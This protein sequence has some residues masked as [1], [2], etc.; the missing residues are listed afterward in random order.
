VT[1]A[2]G[3]GNGFPMAAVVTTKEV[4]QSL[5]SAL[6]LNTFGGNPM[7]CAVGDAVLDVIADERLQANC[8]QVGEHFLK[9]LV[10]LK[11]KSPLI[12]DVRGKGLMIGVELVEDKKL[13]TP[14]AP[15][16]MGALFEQIKDNGV[17]IGKGGLY[18]NV[19]RIKPPMCI[20]KENVDEVCDVFEKVLC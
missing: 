12:G 7:A 17:L 19:L 1:M 14:L 11:E 15:A 3:I 9:K 2:K 20:T 16:K 13:R 18:G 5:T 6:H 10:K 4:A 8:A